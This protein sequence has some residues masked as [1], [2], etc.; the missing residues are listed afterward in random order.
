MA[1]SAQTHYGTQSITKHFDEYGLR[2]WERLVATPVDEV[3]LFIHN[4]YLKQYVPAGRRILDIGAGA[5]RFTQALA[6]CRLAGTLRWKKSVRKRA[7]G[8]NYCA[9]NWKPVLKVNR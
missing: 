2:E 6:A 1:G 7:G 3:S 8:T 5:G 4:H 9:W